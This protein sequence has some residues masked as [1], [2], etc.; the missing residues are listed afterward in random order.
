MAAERHVAVITAPKGIP[1]LDRIP[2]LTN[3][4]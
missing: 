1:A 2:G 3:I 4:M